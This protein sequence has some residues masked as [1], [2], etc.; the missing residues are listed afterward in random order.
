V[1]SQRE[2]RGTALC[3]ITC[4]EARIEL[5][6]RVPESRH[7]DACDA[8]R[9]RLSEDYANVTTSPPHGLIGCLY[10][11]LPTVGDDAY[12][13]VSPGVCPTTTDGDCVLV[14][15]NSGIN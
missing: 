11:D 9:S 7:D 13:Q 14:V 3:V 1:L 15:V 12:L 4:D 8:I 2:E 5:T 6:F 10:A